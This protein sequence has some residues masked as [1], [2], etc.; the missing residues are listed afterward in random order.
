M[1]VEFLQRV[2][3]LAAAVE[4]VTIAVVAAFVVVHILVVARVE[5]PILGVDGAFERG[6]SGPLADPRVFDLGPLAVDELLEPVV[7]PDQAVLDLRVVERVGA[8]DLAGREL[9]GE[10]DDVVALPLGGLGVP[11]L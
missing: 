3:G 9:L 7:V 2:D 8:V 4:V 10:L 11:L 1:A 5:A 6:G